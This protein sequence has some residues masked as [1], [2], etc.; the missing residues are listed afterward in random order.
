[1]SAQSPLTNIRAADD[2][3]SVIERIIDH[4]AEVAR[5]DIEP[6]H[7]FRDVLGSTLQVG[8]TSKSLLWRASTEGAWELVGEVPP[9]ERQVAGLHD[10]RQVILW[11][12]A[13]DAQLRV[14]KLPV[15]GAEISSNGRIE[16]LHV[17]VPI[18]H[19]NQ[20]VAILESVQDRNEAGQLP[21][22]QIHFFAMLS[23]LIAD[24]FAQRELQQLR[25]SRDLWQKWDEYFQ[26][27]SRSLDLDFVCAVIANDGR[28]LAECDRISVLK[29]DGRSGELRAVS[30]VER[31]EPRSSA[32]QSLRAIADLAV[33]Q[34]RPI[35]HNA[36]QAI[37]E[38]G[39]G[40]K[41]QE[42][43][44]RHF[45]DN[46]ATGLGI[47]P[48]RHQPETGLET[49]YFAAIV[50]EQFK[51]IDN[52]A[53]WQNRC[54]LLAKRSTSTLYAAVER[55]QIPFLRFWQRLRQWPQAALK[56][57]T[58]TA[59]AVLVAI[60]LGL[61]LIPTEFTVSG[62][63]ELWP[64][65]RREVFASSSGVVDEIFVG[66]GQDVKRGD[67]LIVLRDQD[68]ET[69]APRITGEIATTNE[70]LK[71]IQAARLAG[72]TGLDA[73]SRA[74]QLTADE[75]ELKVRLRTL[76]RQRALVEE[77]KSALTLRSP[78]DGK[79]L[80][81]DV[82]Q[83]LSARPVERGQSLLTVGDTSGEWVVEVRV[84]DKDVGHILRARKMTVPELDV[85]FILAS[86]PGHRYR[87]QIREMSLNSEY[88]DMARSHVR[89]VIGFD[90]SQLDRP[91][92]GATVI[93]RIHCGRMSLGYVW[94][95]DLVDTIRT[96]IVF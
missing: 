19:S 79:V 61:I 21:S 68:L 93:P 40:A 36:S 28:L 24:F 94:L 90:R 16:A 50:F 64:E 38:T 63:A 41:F 18:R 7:F 95:H 73:V 4:L 23:E 3:R 39:D 44:R 87:G 12:I 83:L 31:I 10:Q 77:R 43:V 56:P 92:P 34:G 33:R 42:S 20:T 29:Y 55:S 5:S 96:R 86:D 35:W 22:D 74:R 15:S 67:P 81:W 71:G 70:R 65:Q 1:M 85:D 84:T 27:L 60:V 48:I 57:S 37:A 88:D 75:E 51:P 14:L 30:G 49:P 6:G 62:V 11:D 76:E 53:A 32:T 78:I 66:H 58:L 59:M 2:L 8:G 17:F 72:G 54:E 47:V 82:A 9:P 89:M 80:T 69:D 45:S 91:R 26:R 52:F 25:R 46:K 13:N